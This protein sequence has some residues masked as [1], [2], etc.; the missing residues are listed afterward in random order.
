METREA[1]KILIKPHKCVEG[2]VKG[3][4]DTSNKIII[5]NEY[6]LFALV[7]NIHYISFIKH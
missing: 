3:L 1:L 6:G 4:V 5:P 2:M 7:T